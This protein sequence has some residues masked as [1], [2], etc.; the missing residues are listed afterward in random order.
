MHAQALVLQVHFAAFAANFVRLAGYWLSQPQ[1]ESTP[2]DI[3]SVKQMVRVCART[4]AWVTRVG[5]VQL[6]V[7]VDYY[8]QS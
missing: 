3:A 4:S 5:V 1:V 8:R 6:Q 2:F 7:V